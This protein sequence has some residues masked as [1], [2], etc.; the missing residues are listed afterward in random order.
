MY[1]LKDSNGEFRLNSK[2]EVQ[3]DEALLQKHFLEAIELAGEGSWKTKYFAGN[4][5]LT[6]VYAEFVQYIQTFYT[7]SRDP[8]YLHQLAYGPKLFCEA[9]QG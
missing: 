2:G 9:L 8:K 6:G 5:F 7:A 3:Y 1:A 4:D